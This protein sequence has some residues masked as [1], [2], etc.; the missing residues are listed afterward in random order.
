MRNFLFILSAIIVLFSSCSGDTDVK[1]ELIK[2]TSLEGDWELTKELFNNQS[3]DCTENPIKTVLSFK[4]NGY[5]IYFDDLTHSGLSGEIDKI[6]M[7]FR[8]QY[9]LE[10][11][12]LTLNHSENDEESSEIYDIKSINDKSLVIVNTD[13]SKELH[14][15]K[16]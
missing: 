3:F 8:G 12:V 7:H 9:S 5:F 14:Y 6:Q 15:T 10:E 1:K 2:I 4:E 13:N 11:N 16:R